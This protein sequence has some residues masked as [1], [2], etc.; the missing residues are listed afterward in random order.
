[1]SFKYGANYLKTLEEAQHWE[2]SLA[3]SYGGSTGYLSAEECD[4]PVTAALIWGSKKYHRLYFRS[5]EGLLPEE[6][7]SFGVGLVSNERYKN[8]IGTIGSYG[9]TLDGEVY[10]FETEEEAWKG[11]AG[12]EFVRDVG[13]PYE[14]PPT[15]RLVVYVNE[16]DEEDTRIEEIDSTET[17]L[18]RLETSV[19]RMEEELADEV[20]RSGYY[21]DL[22][23]KVATALGVEDANSED[24]DPSKLA[25]IA[26]ALAKPK[27]PPE[28]AFGTFGSRKELLSKQMEL[29]AK[30]S[31]RMRA[32]T[33]SFAPGLSAYYTTYELSPNAPKV[34]PAE[35]PVAE[36]PSSLTWPVMLALSVAAV[37]TG[38][39]QKKV[40]P[41]SRVANQEELA[42]EP[43]ERKEA[44]ETHSNQVA[45]VP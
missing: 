38:S 30:Q 20:E 6:G 26:S 27:D 29:L 10:R 19:T 12:R 44:H 31:S 11:A 4:H 36:K 23:R 32:K 8:A 40:L 45:Q 9:Y 35:E 28:D 7:L 24:F 5:G 42:E 21:L 33:F 2:A 34:E 41:P 39:S 37:A 15:H 17:I 13:R 18:D 1:M 16:D 25:G 43:E 22:L 3:R 14:E